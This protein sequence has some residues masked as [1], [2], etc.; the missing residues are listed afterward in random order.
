M[1][2]DEGETPEFTGRAVC[3]LMSDRK[4]MKKTGKQLECSDLAYEYLFTDIN[5]S[6]H[7]SINSLYGQYKIAQQYFLNYLHKKFSSTK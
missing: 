1:N 4:I 5:G 7:Y 2:V 3:A 6:R